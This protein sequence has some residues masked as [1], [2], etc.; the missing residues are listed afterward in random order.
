MIGS[1][2]GRQF[3]SELDLSVCNAEN[4]A[5]LTLFLRIH[6]Q[7]VDP[8]GG[9]GTMADA[10]GTSRR[11]SAWPEREWTAFRRRYQT[12][13]QD[14]WTGRFWLVTPDSFTE[15]DWA[16]QN[17]THRPNVFCRLRVS[18]VDSPTGAHHSIRCVHL[19]NTETFF[20]SHA[21]LFDSR[22]LESVDYGNGQHQ[23]THVHEL[24]HLLGL[25]HA[26]QHRPECFTGDTNAPVCYGFNG[27]ESGDIMGFGEHR[28]EWHAS[29][30]RGAISRH[31]GIDE[32]AWPVSLV[33]VFPRRLTNLAHYRLGHARA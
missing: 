18:I 28:S 13:C 15:M 16:A 30:W 9:T 22:D 4:N 2:P 11:I 33:R 8:P 32:S 19:A 1:L 7:R 17:P 14:F 3:D 20:R 10:G 26:S 29:P 24:G 23:R 27:V 21:G 25:G 5:N 31:T 6:L 12:Q